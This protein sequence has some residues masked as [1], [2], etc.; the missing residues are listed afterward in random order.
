VWLVA[1]LVVS[2]AERGHAGEDVG[3]VAL[4]VAGLG[5]GRAVVAQPVRL[6]DKAKLGPV[7][8]DLEAVDELFGAGRGEAGG[9][10]DRAE[11][12]LQVGIRE[13]EGALVQELA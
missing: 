12:D 2:E 1:D 6:H 13:A 5:R 8:V 4:G 3:T 7:E 9:L 11:E 10:R